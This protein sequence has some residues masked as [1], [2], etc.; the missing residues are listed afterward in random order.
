MRRRE[1]AVERKGIHSIHG[2]LEWEKGRRQ[3]Y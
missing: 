3:A 2:Y 1:I